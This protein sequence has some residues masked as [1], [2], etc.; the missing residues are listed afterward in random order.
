MNLVTQESDAIV[1]RNQCEEVRVRNFKIVSE[2]CNNVRLR[3]FLKDKK[4]VHR[5]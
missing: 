2:A 5:N 3:V 1:G 4:L